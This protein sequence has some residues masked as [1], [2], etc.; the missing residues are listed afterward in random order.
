M[1]YDPEVKE[2]S[3]DVVQKRVKVGRGTVQ[4]I[5]EKEAATRLDSLTTIAQNLGVPVWRLLQGDNALS[6]AALEA[7][8][9][10]D[11]IADPEKRKSAMLTLNAY[12]P[13]AEVSTAAALSSAETKRAR[14]LSK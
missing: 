13:A 3:I 9:L 5:K 11:K 4:R 1:G 12:Q 10:Y 14:A 8:T 7:A 2:P 6:P